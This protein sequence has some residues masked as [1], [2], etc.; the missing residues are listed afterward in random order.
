MEWNGMETVIVE[1]TTNILPVVPVI[2]DTGREW[3]W[4]DCILR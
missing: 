1:L 3:I 2:D 4:R